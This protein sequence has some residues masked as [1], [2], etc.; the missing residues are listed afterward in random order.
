MAK[1]VPLLLAALV[2][3]G[4]AG[5]GSSKT[6]PVRGTIHFKDGEVAKELAGGTVEFESL[7]QRVSARGDIQAD[8]TFRLTTY[9]SGDGAVPGQHKVVIVPRVQNPDRPGPPPVIHPRYERLE[10]TDLVIT[11]E[12]KSNN[13]RLEVDRPR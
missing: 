10:T 1:S 3:V 11:V 4:L 2:A 5:C 6:H 8:G 9:D 13:L 12:R 7:D